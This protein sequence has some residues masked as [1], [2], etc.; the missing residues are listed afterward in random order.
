MKRETHVAYYGLANKN[1]HFHSL[2]PL[3]LQGLVLCR[4]TLVKGMLAENKV[5]ARGRSKVQV[6]DYS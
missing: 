3:G 5:F 4:R 1:I 2:F 6:V